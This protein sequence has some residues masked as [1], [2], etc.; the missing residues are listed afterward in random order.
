[1]LASLRPPAGD[2]QGKEEAK[3]KKK[4]A[5]SSF[6][7]SLSSSK[8]K[9]EKKQ[10][11]GKERSGYSIP[12]GGW[13]DLVSCPHY[14]AEVVIYASLAALA[15]KPRPMVLLLLFVVVELSFSATTQHAWY[16]AKFEDYPKRRR[17]IFPRLL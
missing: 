11:Q 8:E 6:S 4:G 5:S 7:S 13:F 9:K 10:Q 12:R 15:H 17:A 14:L 2:A 16:K 1:M 3:K